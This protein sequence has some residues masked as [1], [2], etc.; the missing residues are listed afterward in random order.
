MR[1]VL[2]IFLVFVLLLSVSSL[3][4]QTE[5]SITKDKDESSVVIKEGKKVSDVRSVYV[6]YKPKVKHNVNV[7]Q[8]DAPSASTKAVKA[9]QKVVTN[10]KSSKVKKIYRKPY[11]EKKNTVNSKTVKSTTL[12]AKSAD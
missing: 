11:V 8:N 2:W 5:V 9:S 3:Y 10:K 12:E 4:A 1:K 6:P 7:I